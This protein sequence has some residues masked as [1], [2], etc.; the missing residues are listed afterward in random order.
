MGVSDDNRV[1]ICEVGKSE[2]EVYA[3]T[4]SKMNWCT[5]LVGC[6][7]KLDLEPCTAYVRQNLRLTVSVPVT[8]VIMVLEL[9][10]ICL[11]LISVYC[12]DKTVLC[13]YY[14]TTIK[15][16]FMQIFRFV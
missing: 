12:E 9:F 1:F 10:T 7:V 11:L 3:T 8:A 13:L 16:P 2:Y 4:I 5:S 14:N 15:P 6:L